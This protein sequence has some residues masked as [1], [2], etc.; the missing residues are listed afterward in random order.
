MSVAPTFTFNRGAGWR[1]I[2]CVASGPSLS[3]AQCDLIRAAHASREW[4]VI[5]VNGAWQYVQFADILFAA[6][7]RWWVRYRREV[8]ASGFM[9]ELWT[10]D[11]VV[12]QRHTL[13]YIDAMLGDGMPRDPTMISRASNS[14]GQAVQLGARLGGRDILLAGYDM[15]RT[16]GKTHVHGDHPA[17]LSNDDPAKWLPAFPPLARDLSTLGVRVRNCSIDTALDCWPR[18]SLESALTLQE[19]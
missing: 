6:D 11:R 19:A 5:A 12:A 8:M 10:S 1:R 13:R 17:P 2:I 15:Q 9:G 3:P 4:R 16:G 14:G 7:D 18:E